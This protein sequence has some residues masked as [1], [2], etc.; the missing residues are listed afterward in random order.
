MDKKI[1]FEYGFIEY[2]THMGTD[3][4]HV[5]A[6]RVSFGK[7]KDTY[8]NKDQ[9][10]INYLASNN[11]TSPFRHCYLQVHVKCPEFVARQWYKHI[12]GCDYTFKDTGWNEISSRYVEIHEFWKPDYF[13]QQAID[14]KQGSTDAP[15]PRS[16]YWKKLYIEHIDRTD[17]L[18]TEMVADGVAI[19]QARTLLG[20]NMYTEF[21]W[22]A[23]FQAIAHFVNLRY[24]EHAQKEIRQYAIALDDIAYTIWTNS[25]S[26][27]SLL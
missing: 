21:Y 6:A 4:T 10:L 12:I 22:S 7:R 3:L 17:F 27:R 15:H 25:W 23:S 20:L 16:D 26:V 14:K 18:Y 9:K 11:H 24:D 1:I 13:R 2:I 19:E 5:N 8:D